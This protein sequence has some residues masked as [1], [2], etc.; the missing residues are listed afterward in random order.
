MFDIAVNKDACL[1]DGV[2]INLADWVYFQ[3]VSSTAASWAAIYGADII[4]I[5]YV[6]RWDI[7]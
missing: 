7:L 5:R 6:V 4:T 3:S 2:N 1:A